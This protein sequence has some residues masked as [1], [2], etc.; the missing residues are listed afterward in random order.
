MPIAL[1]RLPVNHLLK[2][3]SI[4]STIS[5]AA[6]PN[7]DI[8]VISALGFG[9]SVMGC[10]CSII[11]AAGEFGIIGNSAAFVGANAVVNCLP[12]H[13]NVLKPASLAV[14]NASPKLS[15]VEMLFILLS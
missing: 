12:C 8:P 14:L 9:T 5:F 2:T 7:L 6:V 15:I 4:V 11:L 13:S 1:P 3:L 10:P